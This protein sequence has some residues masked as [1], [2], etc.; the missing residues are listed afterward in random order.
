MK[1]FYISFIAVLC[2]ITM[3]VFA[4]CSADLSDKKP[5]QEF[6]DA[7]AMQ[8]G[9]LSQGADLRIMSFNALVHIKSWGG[10]E[11][12]PRA[13]QAIAMI[14][15]YL[16]DVIGLQEVCSDWNK[17]LNA[18]LDN[19]EMLHGKRN[20]FS[21]NYSPIIYNTDTLELLSDGYKLFTERGNKECR[22]VTWGV[23]KR[24]SDGKVF[25]VTNTHFDLIR[26]DYEKWLNIMYSQA[27]E[28]LEII[29]DI[30]GEQDCVVYSCGD[31]NSMDTSEEYQAVNSLGENLG[32]SAASEVYYK[33]AT[34]NYTGDKTINS[35]DIRDTKYIEGIS[36]RAGHSRFFK[37]GDVDDLTRPMEGNILAPS[38]DHIFVSNAKGSEVK[39]FTMLSEDIYKSMS[40]H[41]AIFADIK[42]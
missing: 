37:N 32:K 8:D 41:F 40:D 36:R 33:I 9:E 1:K 26:E 27:N 42:L 24:K 12:E 4:G 39:S 2:L 11:V 19:Y 18:N 28:L 13:V 16:P 35:F 15:K 30:V 14:N 17:Y 25:A 22:S 6:S 38:Y 29:S 10:E 7:L 5:T 34:R 3:L 20:I 23:F 31:Y 21:Y